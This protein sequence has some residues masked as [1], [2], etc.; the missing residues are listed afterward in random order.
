MFAHFFAGDRVEE[1]PTAE[2][3]ALGLPSIHPAYSA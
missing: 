3:P 2:V 1:P